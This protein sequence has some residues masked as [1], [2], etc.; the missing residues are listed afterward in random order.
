MFGENYRIF[1][2]KVYVAFDS[3][4]NKSNCFRFFYEI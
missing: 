4:D 2:A 1:K 3:F